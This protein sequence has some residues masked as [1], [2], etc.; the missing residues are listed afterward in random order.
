VRGRLLRVAVCRS[1]T[2]C[3]A[4]VGLLFGQ[5][6]LLDRGPTVGPEVSSPPPHSGLN[7]LLTD[8]LRF[9]PAKHG[10]VQVSQCA[11]QSQDMG[12][13]LGSPFPFPAVQVR[14]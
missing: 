13:A 1:P 11:A 4:G 9:G 6:T 5:S 14:L 12:A 3:A 8:G 2:R 10:P 7:V